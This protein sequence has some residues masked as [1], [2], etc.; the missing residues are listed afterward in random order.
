M[1]MADVDIDPVGDHDKTDEQ[2]YETGETISF[3][4]GGVIEEKSTWKP[5]R[6]Q[7]TSFGGGKTQSAE[8]K[9]L[10]VEG[11]YRKLSE[12]TGQTPEAFH[13]D[14]FELRDGKLY[15]KDKRTPLTNK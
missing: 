3:T 5:Q 13:F 8:L 12:T 14:Y 2:S 11:L 1:K 15:Y 6:E 4:P 9:E 10:F 7:E